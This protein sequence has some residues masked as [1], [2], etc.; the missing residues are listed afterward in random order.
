MASPT[1]DS[2]NDAEFFDRLFADALSLV[3]ATRDL[4]ARGDGTGA[5][6]DTPPQVRMRAARDVSRLTCRATAAM[7][8]LL[9][10][11]A[12]EDG[13]ADEIDDVPGRLTE[14]YAE[15]EAPTPADNLRDV[16]LPE[17]VAALMARADGV[18]DRVAR[19]HDMIRR[20]LAA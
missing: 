14:L 20:R 7:S 5:G 4:L 8:V 11:K 3:E 19:I 17:P 12:L 16:P 9:L 18:F 2:L 13:Q 6:T 10:Y 1:D 15:V